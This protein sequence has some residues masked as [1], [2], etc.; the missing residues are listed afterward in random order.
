[1]RLG[2]IHSKNADHCIRSLAQNR[3]GFF[4][5]AQRIEAHSK[6]LPLPEGD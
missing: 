4:G 5:A 3:F 6:I 1:M 2:I